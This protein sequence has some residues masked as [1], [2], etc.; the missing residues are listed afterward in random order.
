MNES[1][2]EQGRYLAARSAFIFASRLG[3]VDPPERLQAPNQWQISCTARAL[4]A[5]IASGRILR[6][7]RAADF[8][9][10]SNHKDQ[11]QAEA[12]AL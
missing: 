7:I 11:L 1:L 3:K 8:P 9:A 12:S 6:I 10:G 4:A 2:D 5:A